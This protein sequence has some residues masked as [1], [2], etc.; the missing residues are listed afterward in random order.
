[1]TLLEHEA[2]KWLSFEELDSVDWLPADVFVVNAIKEHISRGNTKLYYDNQAQDFFDSTVSADVSL[3]YERFLKYIQANGHIL[4]F[5]CGSGRDTKAFH[6]MGY[7]VSALDGSEE[8]CKLAREYSGI[9]VKC[10]DFLSLNEQSSYDAIW[11]CA[12]IIHVPSD[13]L[14]VLLGKMRDAVVDDGIIYAS[15]KYGD[16]EGERNGR[17]FVDMTEERFHDLLGKVDGLTI[18]EEWTSGDVRADKTGSWYDVI[19]RKG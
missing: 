11:A 5:G 1:M 2:A 19:L 10:A 7:T 18:V 14:L 15:F 17:F 9:P 13:Q 12:S 8:L 16:F 4:D 6:D 3:L